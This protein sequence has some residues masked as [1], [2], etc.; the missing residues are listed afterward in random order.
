MSNQCP[1]N[2]VWDKILKK[3]RFP[4]KIGRKPVKKRN[5]RGGNLENENEDNEFISSAFTLINDNVSE[6]SEERSYQKK[7]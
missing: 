5:F 4:L 7:K 2:L 1:K 3:C 6:N